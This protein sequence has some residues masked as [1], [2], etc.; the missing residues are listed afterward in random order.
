[1]IATMPETIL[2]ITLTIRRMAKADA[3]RTHITE[4]EKHDKEGNAEFSSEEDKA[5]RSGV[6]GQPG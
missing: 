4:M 1:M 3:E 2:S 5:G 6:Q